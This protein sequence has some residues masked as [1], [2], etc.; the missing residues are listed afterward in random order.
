MELVPPT[1]DGGGEHHHVYHM[2]ERNNDGS[3]VITVMSG[4][5][6]SGFGNMHRLGDLNYFAVCNTYHVYRERSV[7]DLCLMHHSLA[8]LSAEGAEI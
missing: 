5:Y 6:P 8:S 1:I 2:R 4:I 3:L 7:S